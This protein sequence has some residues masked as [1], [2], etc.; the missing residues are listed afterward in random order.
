MGFL[1][2]SCNLKAFSL[3]PQDHH[4]EPVSVSMQIVEK[5]LERKYMNTASLTI[6]NFL[7]SNSTREMIF[8]LFTYFIPLNVSLTLVR[9]NGTNFGLDFLGVTFLNKLG[10]KLVFVGRTLQR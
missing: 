10:H 4:E 9:K 1:E 7:L 8:T 5:I 6:C 3:L 2:Q